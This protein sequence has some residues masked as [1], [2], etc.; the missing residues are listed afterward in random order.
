M[1]RRRCHSSDWADRFP[2]SVC[3]SAEG[4]TS[5]QELVVL[6]RST[7][8]T[9]QTG[10]GSPRIDFVVVL[11]FPQDSIWSQQIYR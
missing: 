8:K 6:G 4:V 2:R 10:Q 5:K 7:G 3:V 11:N 1:P 9:K